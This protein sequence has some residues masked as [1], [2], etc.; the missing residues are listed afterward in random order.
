MRC[1]CIRTASRPRKRSRR[2]NRPRLRG[3]IEKHVPKGKSISILSGEWGYSSVW[4]GK[5]RPTGEIFGP[6][7]AD[8]FVKRCALSIWYDWHD[9][10]TKANEPEHHFG[11]V[12]HAYDP[13]RHTRR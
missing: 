13:S 2:I 10:G 5:R 1:R 9:D 3:M 8:Q 11:T 6:A 7:M 12:T 4:E